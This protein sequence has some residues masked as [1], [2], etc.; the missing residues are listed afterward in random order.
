MAKF[1]KDIRADEDICHMSCPEV[2]AKHMAKK[3][4]NFPTAVEFCCGVGMTIVQLARTMDKVHGVDINKRYIK[5][6][7]H[8]AKLYGVEDKL[9]LICGDCLDES[10]VKTIKAD[11]AIVDPDWRPIGEA[12]QENHVHVDS[13]DETQPSLKEMSRLI[14]KH[15][16]DN[17]VFRLPNTFS[18][19]ALSSLG[20]CELESIKWGGKT[21]FK[22]AYFFGKL[23]NSK[24]TETSFEIISLG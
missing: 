3:L 11:V 14:K 5:D 18:L 13:I 1:S 6:T 19:E 7:A 15:I 12:S 20:N 16:T 24:E 10:I 22:I 9:E 23:N 8:N 21:K 4:S 17:M 2:V